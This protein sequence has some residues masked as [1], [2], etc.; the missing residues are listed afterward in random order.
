MDIFTHLGVYMFNCLMIC[1]V[2]FFSIFSLAFNEVQ[3]PFELLLRISQAK[4]ISQIP[5]LP[6]D[7][8]KKEMLKSYIK[9]RENNLR[10]LSDLKL[11]NFPSS[12]VQN[13]V[14]NFLQIRDEQCGKPAGEYN[15]EN[16]EPA[17]LP[18][19]LEWLS[20]LDEKEAKIELRNELKQM[21]DT[22]KVSLAALSLL[23]PRYAHSLGILSEDERELLL[24]VV[25][26]PGRNNLVKLSE[27]ELW[28]SPDFAE[29]WNGFH[30]KFVPHANS[31]RRGEIRNF[32]DEKI[33]P[34]L[35]VPIKVSMPGYTYFSLFDL[36]FYTINDCHL[37][38]IPASKEGLDAHGIKNFSPLGFCIH[39]DIHA[40]L[41]DLRR[42]AFESFI[43]NSQER[44]GMHLSDEQAFLGVLNYYMTR[45]LLSHILLKAQLE[46]LE[47]GGKSIEILALFLAIHEF[48]RWSWSMFEL[49][50]ANARTFVNSMVEGAITTLNH[51]DIWEDSIDPLKTSPLDGSAT[52]T[53][54]NKLF[55]VEVPATVQISQ[56]K[57]FVSYGFD[58]PSGERVGDT[59]PTLFHKFHNAVDSLA[60]LEMGGII[61]EKPELSGT[62][63]QIRLKAV[64]FIDRVRA[65]MVFA[66]EMLRKS[67]E[68]YLEDVDFNF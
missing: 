60:L 48:P 54:I 65:H 35:P 58:L 67:A 1:S 46:L 50:Y 13:F 8:V 49:S 27:P 9:L 18:R 32:I 39:D 44:I 43:E 28:N 21:I 23:G 3:Y 61:L 52:L 33:S 7:S 15:P 10:L 31:Y 59:I 19:A 5:D 40:E 12:D 45:E 17:L 22:G 34:F 56:T 57:R 55:R 53:M 30:P 24:S 68:R 14:T 47:E 42:L 41:D 2:C 20:F 63:K 6:E 16:Y 62:E 64:K 38:G 11:Q 37:L 51:A 25:S 29:Y 4:E 26:P 66:M 36:C